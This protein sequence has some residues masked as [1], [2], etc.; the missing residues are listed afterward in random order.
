MCDRTKKWT[1]ILLCP[2]AKTGK[3]GARKYILYMGLVWPGDKMVKRSVS[4]SAAFSSAPGKENV[5][6][7]HFHYQV[8]SKVEE[9]KK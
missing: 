7:S 3:L 6:L 1:I 9:F 8:K 4:L 5:S 2:K